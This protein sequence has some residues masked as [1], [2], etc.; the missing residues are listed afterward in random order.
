MDN[1]ITYSATSL[2]DIAEH[3]DTFATGIEN[4]LRG[5]VPTQLLRRTLAI[6]ARTWREAAD[7]LRRTTIK[8][9]D[10]SQ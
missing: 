2:T 6:E 8:E 10:N 3:F 1:I 9:K 4:R 7:I 5:R